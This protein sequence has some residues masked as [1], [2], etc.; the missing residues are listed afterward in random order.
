MTAFDLSGA[1]VNRIHTAMR[2]APSGD[3]VRHDR[4]CFGLFLKIH[5]LTYACSETQ[6]VPFE[7]DRVILL[8]KGAD[9]RITTGIPR[10]PGETFTIEFDCAD[11]FEWDREHI[12]SW[13]LND[14]ALMFS[15][16]SEA[17]RIWTFK[18][19]AF[20]PR[21]MSIL[22]RIFAELE[23]ERIYVA[24]PG[25]EKLRSALVCFEERFSDPTL[26]VDDLAD[27]AGMSRS[28]FTKLFGKFYGMPPAEYM[29][30]IRIDKAKALLSEGSLSVG[31]VAESV[32]FSSLYYFSAAFRRV[33]G[34]S[35]VSIL[36]QDRQV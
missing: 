12:S 10:D 13:K 21:C 28:Y 36:R 27:A 33:T 16:F 9:Y 4:P 7:P 34:V 23:R 20:Y 6:K 14:P 30:M 19:T 11:G 35:P 22:Y 24:S 18:K 32:G 25:R 29:R 17:A 5:G 3:T 31:E 2:F 26:S 8:P 15:L 1:P